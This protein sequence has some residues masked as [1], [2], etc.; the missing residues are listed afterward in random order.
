[1]N[2]EGAVVGTVATAGDWHAFL[3]SDGGGMVDLTPP[4]V[5]AEAFSINSGGEVVGHADDRA[6]AWTASRGLMDLGTLVGSFST[7][8]VPRLEDIEASQLRDSQDV[9]GDTCR[10]S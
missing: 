4:A 1:M 3:R 2:S 8:W 6:F 7:V 9:E 10:D 5:H